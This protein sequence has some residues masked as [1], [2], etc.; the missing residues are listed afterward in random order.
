MD[1]KPALESCRL[2]PLQAQA[3]LQASQLLLAQGPTA[4][5]LA[6]V[7]G[8]LVTDS[9]LVKP[10][11]L[12]L[13]YRGV[14]ADG[15][16]HLAMAVRL[17]AQLIICEEPKNIPAAVGVPWLQVGDARA[18]WAYLAAAAFENPQQKLRLFGITGT[19]GKTSTVWMLGELLRAAGHGCLTLGTLGAFFGSEEWPLR[20]TTPDPDVL[21]A[22][23]AH[24]VALGLPFAVMEVSSHALCQS[25]VAPLT[26][27]GTAFTSFSRDHL[28]FHQ[29]LDAY[30]LAKISLF[31][32]QHEAK[33]QHVFS[34]TLPRP[35][36]STGITGEILTYREHQHATAT[37]GELQIKIHTMDA[38][39]T[40]LTLALGRQRVT[41][42]VPYFSSHALQN[43]AAAYLL[44]AKAHGQWLPSA[45]WSK[46][47]P[48][49]GRLEQVHKL[50]GPMVIVDFAHTPDALDKTLEVLRPLCHGRLT[51]VFGCGGDRDRGK[52]AFMGRIAERRADRVIVTS[53][54][55]RSENIQS[56]IDEICAGCLDQESIIKILDRDLAI[57]TAIISALPADLVLIAG[58]GHETE[59]IFADRTLPF[60]DRLVA[61]H[62]LEYIE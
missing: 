12:F 11:D 37:P 53:D 32:R 24:A 52:R 27:E 60:D 1:M 25:K 62:Y 6:A 16:D 55:P 30:W 56:I 51:V 19:N 22:H 39:G 8:T 35:I 43:F 20:H 61:K 58:K 3:A 2:T 21:F 59:Q 54:N 4:T 15:H 33:A 34:N 46:L 9:R 44:A 36:P 7:S 49:P 57:K 17:G 48:V 18:A 28:D 14:H 13:A 29:D 31:T 5:K 47:R 40:T 41:G 38:T 26:F 50:G 42:K 10:G 23:L 45:E